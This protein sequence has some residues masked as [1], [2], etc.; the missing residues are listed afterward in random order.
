MKRE[1]NEKKNEKKTIQSRFHFD[2]LSFCAILSS[3]SLAD[4]MTSASGN[5]LPTTSASQPCASSCS[6]GARGSDDGDAVD[7]AVDAGDAA[8]HAEAAA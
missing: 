2:S 6:G 8:A 5:N 3:S 1:K 7:G 4:A